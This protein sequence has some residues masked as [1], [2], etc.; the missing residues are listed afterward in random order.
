M[1]AVPEGGSTGGGNTGGHDGDATEDDPTG[2]P[3]TDEGE[4]VESTLRITSP[5]GGQDVCE[6]GGGDCCLGGRRS[7]KG[8]GHMSEIYSDPNGGSTVMSELQ[9]FQFADAELDIILFQ[10]S[11]MAGVRRVGQSASGQSPA[12]VT[13]FE[14]DSCAI[15]A[16]DNFCS[17]CDNPRASE[18]NVIVEAP[19]VN[20][21]NVTSELPPFRSRFSEG[22]VRGDA[23]CQVAVNQWVVDRGAG[24]FDRFSAAEGEYFYGLWRI[25]S[26]SEHLRQIHD[27][28]MCQAR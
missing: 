2:P 1:V 23:A 18:R 4:G 28:D 24:G 14:G 21:C 10:S 25:C 22:P 6:G 7:S 17:D 13:F 26:V 16:V 12:T 11:T 3:P 15:L 19:R 20:Y 8:H 9:S 5:V 27:E